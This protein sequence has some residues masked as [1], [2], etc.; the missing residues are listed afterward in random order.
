MI[1]MLEDN[2]KVVI[3]EADKLTGVT[4]KK[5]AEFVCKNV[6]GILFDNAEDAISY[7][8]NNPVELVLTDIRLPNM[9]GIIASEIIKYLNKD[10]K[11]IALTAQGSDEFVVASLLANAD[12]YYI[13]DLTFDRL[14][15][16]IENVMTGIF[17]IDYRI[18]YALYNYI[19][20]LPK[21]KSLLLKTILSD[22]EIDFIKIGL[23]GFVGKDDFKNSGIPGYEFCSYTRSVLN[24]FLKFCS[25]D[26]LAQEIEYELF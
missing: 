24:K 20:T 21:E 14:K 13:R 17:K 22:S 2:F 12:A 16:A 3:I 5:M 4:L 6:E 15:A 8:K 23:R 26:N 25:I 7:I 9:N 18:Q 11:I 1:M 19:Q 10:I